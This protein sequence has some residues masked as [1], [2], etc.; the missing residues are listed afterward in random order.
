MWVQ[1]AI[2][3]SAVGA[4]R[5]LEVGHVKARGSRYHGS[6]CPSSDKRDKDVQDK[7]IIG[8]HYHVLT[9]FKEVTSCRFVLPVQ[10]YTWT[11]S[12]YVN[13]RLCQPLWW[14]AQGAQLVV[15]KRVV[16]LYRRPLRRQLPIPQRPALAA[17]P[18]ARDPTDRGVLRPL[19]YSL[20]HPPPHGHLLALVRRTH[21]DG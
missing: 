5:V 6:L 11:T 3:S 1:L 7:R 13:Q 8:M 2:K 18:A 17:A 10:Q 9:Y 4:A 14:D 20:P 15:S 16:S 12:G 21:P 19:R